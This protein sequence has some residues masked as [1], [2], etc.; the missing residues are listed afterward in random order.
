MPLF[1]D[2]LVNIAGKV[3][4]LIELKCPTRKAAP[5][6]EAVNEI[7]KVYPGDYMLQSFNPFALRWFKKNSPDKLRGQLSES[8]ENGTCQIRRALS[9]YGLPG[10]PGF[11][12]L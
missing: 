10:A 1:Q 2:V 5:L 12:I 11:Y 3:P 4:L 6:C 9:A 7:L 8:F